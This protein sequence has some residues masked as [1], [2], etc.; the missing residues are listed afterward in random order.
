MGFV[1]I[2]SYGDQSRRLRSGETLQTHQTESN[3]PR[4]PRP[5]WPIKP[6]I[7]LF[8]C[9]RN[10]SSMWVCLHQH[11]TQLNPLPTYPYRVQGMFGLMCYQGEPLHR[12]RTPLIL[13]LTWC[14]CWGTEA[15]LCEEIKA[16]VQ[17]L[18]SRPVSYDG[19]TQL[20]KDKK[21]KKMH[22][23]THTLLL[24]CYLRL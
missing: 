9:K 17:R 14:W 18:N 2:L 12:V 1:N 5:Q 7:T 8:L 15:M 23:E 21:K 22:T 4:I 6:C 20:G 11:C 3:A 16:A 13:W 10:G 19:E 24:T